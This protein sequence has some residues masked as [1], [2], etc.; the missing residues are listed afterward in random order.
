M[1]YRHKKDPHK[2]IP[3]KK[4]A[5]MENSPRWKFPTV[6]IHLNHKNLT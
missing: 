6:K 2:K 1:I 5:H 4:I 3:R